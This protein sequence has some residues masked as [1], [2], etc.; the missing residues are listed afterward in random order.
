VEV[1]INE[2]LRVGFV[3][4]PFHAVVGK[5]VKCQ[6]SSV[7]CTSGLCARGLSA[8]DMYAY[9]LVEIFPV[10]PYMDPRVYQEPDFSNYW[11]HF[12]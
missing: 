6:S 12:G 9:L 4:T 3:F 10:I 5:Y 7:S 1:E 8:H 11:P 2:T